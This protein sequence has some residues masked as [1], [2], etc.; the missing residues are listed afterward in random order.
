MTQTRLAVVAVE[1]QE[2]AAQVAEVQVVLAVRHWTFLRGV[3]SQQ[4]LREL[5]VAVVGSVR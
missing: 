5:A 3:G 2:Q 1:S 4:I